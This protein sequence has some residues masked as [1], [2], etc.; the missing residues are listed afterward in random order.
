[1]TDTTDTDSSDSTEIKFMDE[2]SQS[3]ETEIAVPNKPDKPDITDI[4]AQTK[5]IIGTKTAIDYVFANVNSYQFKD[6]L[7]C[8]PDKRVNIRTVL[9]NNQWNGFFDTIS[10][11]PYVNGI[12]RI[13]SEFV[14]TNKVIVPCAELLFNAFNILSPRRIRLV[15]L[16]QDPYIGDEQINNKQIFQ[17][18]GCSFSVPYGFPKPPSLKNIY[19]NLLHFGH[20]QSIP[21]SGCLATWIMQ[22]CLL[23]NSSFTTFLG[24]SNAHKQVWQEFTKDLISYLSQT[25]EHVV[26]LAWGKDA[27]MMMLNVDPTKHCIITSSHPSPYAFTNT[28][29]GFEYGLN[30]KLLDRKKVTY[31]SFQSTNHFGK[32]NEYLKLHQQKEIVWDVIDVPI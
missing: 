5:Q 6:W 30:K 18:M 20:V 8:F 21:E 29:Q 14:A 1:M 22:G 31:P 7:E 9:F 32:V 10:T 13:L 2:D 24:R 12:N 4:S 15:L 16:G 28:Y 11:K 27:H 17:A 3:E 26:F 19:D 23:I 25:L